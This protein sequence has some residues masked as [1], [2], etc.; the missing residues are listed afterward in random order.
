MNKYEL[1]VTVD[2]KHSVNEVAY[3]AR[4]LNCKYLNLLLASGKQRNQL[5]FGFEFETPSFIDAYNDFRTLHKFIKTRF[6]ITRFKIEASPGNEN[7]NSFYDDP[8]PVYHEAHWK[9]KSNVLLPKF[10]NVPILISYNWS[11][12]NIEYWT[13]RTGNKIGFPLFHYTYNMLTEYLDGKLIKKPH[14]EH[15]LVD[16]NVELDAGWKGGRR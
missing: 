14:R 10:N 13:I 3:F 4:D 15:V 9:V 11:D 1:H 12:P 5:M 6:D 7:S 2:P 8:K 16:T